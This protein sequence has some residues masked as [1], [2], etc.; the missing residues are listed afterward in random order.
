MPA[1]TLTDLIALLSGPTLTVRTGL[2]LAS[3][4][5]LNQIEDHAARLGID[6]RDLRV[7]IKGSLPEGTRFLGLTVNTLVEALDM[8]CKQFDGSNCLLVYNLDLLLARLHRQARLDFWQYV[9]R[10]FPHRG[11]GLLLVMPSHANHLLPS[12]QMQEA[13]RYD[14]R[15]VD[16]S[17]VN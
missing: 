8:L 2:W 10:G 14:R 9:F 6:A 1:T 17:K 12:T 11:R 13:W 4:H 7:P 5:S 3:I 15:L 16:E